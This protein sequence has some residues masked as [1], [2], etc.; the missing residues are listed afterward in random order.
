MNKTNLTIMFQIIVIWAVESCRRRTGEEW[1]WSF[2]RS[3]RRHD[4]TPRGRRS[5]IFTSAKRWVDKQTG[6]MSYIVS[7][8]AY[9]LHGIQS[10]HKNIMCSFRLRFFTLGS[11]PEGWRHPSTNWGRWGW[12]RN[13]LQSSYSTNEQ[14]TE[15][16]EIHTVHIFSPKNDQFL[17]MSHI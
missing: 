2:K 8:Q 16:G 13:Y 9:L 1:S 14:P 15:T 3:S 12:R 6:C 5:E 17:W 11:T 7:I 10:A 4:H